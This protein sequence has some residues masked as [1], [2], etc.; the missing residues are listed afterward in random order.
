MAAT[1]RPCCSRARLECRDDQV[2]VGRGFESIDYT[3]EA[4]VSSSPQRAHRAIAGR[5]YFGRPF[6]NILDINFGQSVVEDV[7]LASPRVQVEPDLHGYTARAAA[8][9]PAIRPKTAPRMTELAP[10]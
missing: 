4:A 1:K 6:Q 10:G 9:L 8:S 7:R 3:N 5:P 2:A